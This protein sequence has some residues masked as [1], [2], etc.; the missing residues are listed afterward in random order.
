MLNVMKC[1]C[2]S[3]ISCSYLEII[4]FYGGRD[5]CRGFV[6]SLRCIMTMRSFKFR[7]F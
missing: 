4:V 2:T 7:M 5:Q 1:V 6:R 3:E